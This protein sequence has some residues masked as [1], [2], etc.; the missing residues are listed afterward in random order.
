MSAK[1]VEVKPTGQAVY[2]SSVEADGRDSGMSLLDLVLPLAEY[3]RSLVL[4]PLCVGLLTLGATFLITPT[5]TAR[6]TLLPPQQ[7]GGSSAILNS[8]GGLASLASGAGLRP[9]G[10]QYVSMLMSQSIADRLIDKFDLQKVYASEFR[11]LARNQL[12]GSTR[13]ALGKKDG[14]ITIEVDDE[15]PQRAA[16]I[17]NSYIEE[18]RLMSGTLVVTE[19]QQ[20]RAFFEKQL[21]TAR[22][23]LVKAQAALQASGI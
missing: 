9:P 1:P 10:D 22:N 5:F 13:I 8:L 4:V 11:F 6:A 7:Q 21:L 12:A 19:A 15:S 16:D 18:L 2:E 3:W 17:T 20:R 23:S 14:L